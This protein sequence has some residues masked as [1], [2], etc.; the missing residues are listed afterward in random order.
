[1]L[2][3]TIA[4]SAVFVTLFAVGAS[5]QEDGSPRYSFY[6]A[7]ETGYEFFT[8]TYRHSGHCI[9]FNSRYYFGD[10]VY[11]AFLLHGGFYSGGKS[12]SYESGGT[13][14]ETRL[15]NE[16]N[17][18]MA[19]VGAGL[20]LYRSTTGRSAVY[21]TGTVGYGQNTEEKEVLAAGAES[22]FDRKHKGFAAVLSSGYDF[23][24]AGWFIFGAAVNGYYIGDRVNFAANV[25]LGLVF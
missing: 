11:G 9:D 7:I 17:E 10:R 3:K 14:R 6:T 24:P 22:R 1:M 16:L 12:A 25:R 2:R 4:M 23:K 18:W 5:A 8:K 15:R 21:L 20:D 19:G 13:V